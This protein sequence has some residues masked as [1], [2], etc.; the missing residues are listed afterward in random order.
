MTHI[1]EFFNVEQMLFAQAVSICSVVVDLG[2]MRFEIDDAKSG[3]EDR[4]NISFPQEVRNIIQDAITFGCDDTVNMFEQLDT[5]TYSLTAYGV[6][7]GT[8]WSNRI[9]QEQLM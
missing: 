5:D 1:S 9:Q 8:D 2:L 6:A 3:L 4:H 7:I